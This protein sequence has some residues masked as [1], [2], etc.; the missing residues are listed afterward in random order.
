MLFVKY[1]GEI[2][3]MADNLIQPQWMQALHK[4][5]SMP[6][7]YAKTKTSNG[8]PCQAVAMANGRCR[9]HG[10]KS[11]GAPCGAAHGKYKHGL[12]SKQAKLVLHHYKQQLNET[13]QIIQV[14]PLHEF[15]IAMALVQPAAIS[16][17]SALN[18]HTL[19]EQTPDDC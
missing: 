19:T 15:E 1:R 13:K 12:Y 11:T 18:Y 3:K 8:L 7:C 6:R 4:A 16:H 9:M 5:N 2:E 10:G 17:W 14:S